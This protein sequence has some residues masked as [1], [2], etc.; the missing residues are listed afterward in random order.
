M[1]LER[2]VISSTASMP[3]HCVLQKTQLN[4]GELALH[5]A[6]SEPV[7]T[8]VTS[9]PLHLRAAFLL[10]HTLVCCCDVESSC[11]GQHEALEKALRQS[12]SAL[13]TPNRACKP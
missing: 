10:Q 7:R 2:L 11:S 4:A 6:A 9:V 1:T 8:G 13:V 12:L 5:T 3:L